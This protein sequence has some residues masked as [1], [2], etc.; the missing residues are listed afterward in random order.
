ML[1][2]EALPISC[3]TENFENIPTGTS[4]GDQNYLARTWTSNGII[5][6]AS[7]ARTDQTI[8]NKA[9]TVENGALSSSTIS[10]GISS[11]TVKL[12]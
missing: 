10:G 3:G 1:V 4:G 9:I 7:E 6:N 12:K 2:L 8:N 5:W 11:L